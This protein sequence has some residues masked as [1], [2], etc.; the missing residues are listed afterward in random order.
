MNG[1]EHLLSRK[2]PSF[3][4]RLLQSEPARHLDSSRRVD[5]EFVEAR[6]RF[7]GSL[8]FVEKDSGFMSGTALRNLWIVLDL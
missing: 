5:T 7:G 2:L 4:L 8:G 3:I 1:D 6:E